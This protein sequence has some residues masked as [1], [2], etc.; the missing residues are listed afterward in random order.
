MKDGNVVRKDGSKTMMKNGDPMD[1]I[2][3]MRK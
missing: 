3:S 2:G 1:M